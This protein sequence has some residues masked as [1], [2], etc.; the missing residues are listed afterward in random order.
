MQGGAGH[1]GG[2]VAAAVAARRAQARRSSGTFFPRMNDVCVIIVSHNGK[3]WLDAAL[4]HS[5]RAAPAMSTSTSSSSTT[6]TTVPP[7]T[8]RSAFPPRARSA[9]RTTA[10]A[11]P[12]TSAWR[13]PTP[14]TSSSSTPTPNCSAAASRDLTAALDRRPE[15][16]LA[17]VRQVDSHGALS[18]SIRRFP[19]A[20]NMLAEA[21]W[22]ER[23]PGA[24]GSLGERELDPVPYGRETPCDWTSGS[25]M[26]ARREALAADRRLRRELL[27]L[28]RGDRPLLADEAGR[29]GG[30]AHAAADD[31]P[32]RARRRAEPALGSAGRLRPDPVRPQALS[33]RQRPITAGRW[34][35]AMRCGSASTRC[36][37]GAG[38]SRG[39][40]PAPPSAP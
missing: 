7:P 19:S 37:V 33:A 26:I 32:L 36:A 6:A 18:P 3:R 4:S 17:G 10:S 31:P 29:L 5:L 8:S 9:A 23:V 11:T 1:E 2:I 40:V 22:V 35:S 21:L 15:V 13:P 39:S 14:A 24:G 28:L 27:P 16:G 38:A 25:F 34:R 30:H 20:A 12:T